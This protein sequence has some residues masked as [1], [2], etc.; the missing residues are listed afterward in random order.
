MAFVMKLT[1][2]LDAAKIS[3]PLFAGS[4]PPFFYLEDYDPDAHGGRGAIWMTHDIAKALR[5][6][7][8][9]SVFALWRHTSNARPLRDDGKPSRP[10]TA[11]S[12]L[13]AEE[14]P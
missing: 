3:A 13:D 6:P 9:A 8:R 10:L 5:F 7:D 1:A 4:E 12:L 2:E 14:V 11:Y